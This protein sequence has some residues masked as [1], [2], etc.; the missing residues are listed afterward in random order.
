MYL[1]HRALAQRYQLNLPTYPG[2]DLVVRL[3]PPSN[4]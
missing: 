4:L 2:T 1:V 3:P